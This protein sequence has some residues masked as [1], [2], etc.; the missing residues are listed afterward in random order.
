MN[1]LMDHMVVMLQFLCMAA[2]AYG[3]ML[4]FYAGRVSVP[5]RA[6]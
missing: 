5:L 3:M 1:W 2:L 4:S 6:K